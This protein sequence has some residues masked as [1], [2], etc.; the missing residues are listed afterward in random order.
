[1]GFAAAASTVPGFTR[2]RYA[3]AA[4]PAEH[5]M[6][7]ESAS[8]T[9]PAG[10]YHPLFFTAEQFALVETLAELILPRGVSAAGELQ[11]NPPTTETDPDYAGASDAGVAEF[12]DFMVS[13][14]VTLQRPFREGLAWMDAASKPRAFVHRSPE[15]QRALLDRLAYRSKFRGDEET[16]QAFFARMRKLTV[17]GFYTSRIGLESIGYPG[18]RFYTQSPS[19]PHDAFLQS[20]EL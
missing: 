1:M 5:T 9:V 8:V 16:G 18:L 13:Q 10:P 15:A 19:V 2:W 14:D 6:P 7:G 17:M 12:I 11:S 3:F 20:L 4:P